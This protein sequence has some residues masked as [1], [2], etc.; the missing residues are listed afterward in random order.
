[1]KKGS[2]RL[3]NV[4]SSPPHKLTTF[5]LRFHHTLPNVFRRLVHPFIKALHPSVGPWLLTHLSFPTLADSHNTTMSSELNIRAIYISQTE[6]YLTGTS[7]ST[8]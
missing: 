5:A 4:Y 2:I 7:R 6:R 3:Q 8:P 1:M